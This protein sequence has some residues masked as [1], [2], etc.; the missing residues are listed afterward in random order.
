[1]NPYASHISG[2]PLEVI[3]ETPARLAQLAETIGPERLET[4]PAPGKW[5]ARDILCHLA[6]GEVAFGFRLRQ[7]LAEEHHVIQPFDQD[8]WAKGYSASDARLAL[9]AFQALRAWNV[10]L[11][12]GAK[13][14]DWEKPVSHPERGTMTFRTI[15]ETMAGHDRNHMKQMEAIASQAASAS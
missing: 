10:A 14:S 5:S 11:I 8:G 6:D 4:P 9:A 15:V 12:R 3:S 2:T 1:M 13:P 7:T